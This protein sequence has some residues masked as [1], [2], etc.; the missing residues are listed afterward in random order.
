[1]KKTL[2][3]CV[4][5]GMLFAGL[6]VTAMA[7]DVQPP[8]WRGQWSTTSQFWE[9]LTAD[10]GP[11]QPDGSPTGGQPWLPS[12]K[13]TVY[14]IGDWIAYDSPSQREGIWPLS[15]TIDVIVDN[16]EP[17]NEWK[18]VW[19]QL[20]WRSQDGTSEPEIYNLDP[21][22]DSSY[23]LH[24]VATADLGFDWYET[25]YEWRICPNPVDEAFTIGGNIDVDELVIDTWCPEP[26]TFVL[27]G[28]GVL[29][30]AIYGWRRK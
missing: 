12:T 10:T 24:I 18:W 13:L 16:H 1:M 14:P 30:L 8:W 4:A 21:P 19:V 29:G 15:G 3:V 17:P 20:T 6:T 9:F 7:D 2:V 25:T 5:L 11:L 28:M 22:A 26:S 27:L 23:P